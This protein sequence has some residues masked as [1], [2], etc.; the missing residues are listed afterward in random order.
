GRT[1]A[2][3]GINLGRAYIVFNANGTLVASFDRDGIKVWEIPSGRLIGHTEYSYGFAFSPTKDVLAVDRGGVVRLWDPRTDR[4]VFQ[5][6]GESPFCF[7]PEGDL[8]ALTEEKGVA[9]WDVNRQQRLSWTAPGKPQ[10]F[11]SADEL[12]TTNKLDDFLWNV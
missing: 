4:D 2:K 8:L 6:P 10:E 5:A 3:S 9:V 1:V 11:L 7:N 12:V